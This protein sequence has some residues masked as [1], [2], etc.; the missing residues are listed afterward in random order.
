MLIIAFTGP[1]DLAKQMGVER[2]G[3]E[4]EAAIQRILKAAHDAGKAAAIFCEFSVSFASLSGHI[5]AIGALWSLLTTLMI[6]T[7][8]L[9][10]KKRREDGFD[11]IS[12]TTDIGT[13]SKGFASEYADFTGG[14]AGQRDGY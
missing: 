8:G 5:P 10:A 11:M 3:P 14:K 7:D 2:K 6:G 13:V 1:F 4:H 9:D 12:I